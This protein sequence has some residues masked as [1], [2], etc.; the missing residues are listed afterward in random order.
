[1]PNRPS[2]RRL[3]QSTGLIVAGSASPGLAMLAGC[4]APPAPMAETTM[5]EMTA[6][7]ALSRIRSGRLSAEAYVTAMLDRAER[8]K[9]LNALIAVDR[10]GAIAQARKVDAMRAPPA[11]R[12]RCSPACRSSSR[13]TSTAA[14][15]RP[16]AAPRRCAACARRRT[17]RR[18]RS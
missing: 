11:A 5:Q 8:L 12:C 1:M 14:T 18:C 7:E 2:R 15:C 17:R 6:S 16:P 10:A 9:D 13:T 3:L 4:A